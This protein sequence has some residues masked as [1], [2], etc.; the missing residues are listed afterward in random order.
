MLSWSL[1][2]LLIQTFVDFS[3]RYT[4]EVSNVLKRSVWRMRNKL[5]LHVMHHD[6]QFVH[7]FVHA[8]DAQGY[9]ADKD[10]LHRPRTCLMFNPYGYSSGC[11]TA[12]SGKLYRAR[13]RLYRGQILQENM[14]L[15]AL[16]E[17]YTMHSFA[18]LCNLNVWSKFAKLLVFLAKFSKFSKK[19]I[20]KNFTFFWQNQ[21]FLKRKM[22]L[23]SCAKECIV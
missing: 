17:I 4:N 20:V 7:V 5:R 8:L 1:L 14:R 6:S 19:Q 21:A 3:P 22:W 16:A 10:N 2:W 9:A 18:Q 15:K 13:S 11:C 23:Q 12:R